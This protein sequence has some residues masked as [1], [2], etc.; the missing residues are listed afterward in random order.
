[1]G[2]SDGQ[3]SLCSTEIY[4]P[5]TKSWAPGPSMTTCRANVGCAVMDGKLYAVGGFSGKIFLNTIEYLDPDTM[6][7]TTFTPKPEGYKSKRQSRSRAT[8][9]E[10]LIIG[11]DL[12]LEDTIPEDQEMSKL[13]N[14]N[15]GFV[16]NNLQDVY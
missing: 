1:M 14:G 2:G 8:S 11:G 3:Q 10:E 4:D 5:E 13:S 15:N 6:E 9:Q 7:W 16:Y 12:E